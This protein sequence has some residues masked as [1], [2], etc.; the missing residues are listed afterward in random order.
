MANEFKLF[1]WSRWGYGGYLCSYP[2]KT[3]AINAGRDMKR[4]GFA[5]C[6]CVIHNGEVIAKG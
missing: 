2:N 3:Q 6:Y 4:D 1:T 5:W